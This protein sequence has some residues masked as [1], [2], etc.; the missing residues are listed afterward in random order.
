MPRKKR[1]IR[2]VDALVGQ[3]SDALLS[4][5]ISTLPGEEALSGYDGMRSHLADDLRSVTQHL[6]ISVPLEMTDGGET[7]WKFLEPN[8]L[9][10]HVIEACP[11]LAEAYGRA[12]NEHTPT[13][14]D[15]WNL[16]L[17]FDEFVPG[18][19]LKAYAS[20]K[21]MV[22]GFNFKELGEEILCKDHSWFIPV[23][24]RSSTIH[25]VL[26]GWS[27]MLAKFLRAQLLGAQGLRTSG[28]L[29]MINGSP[30]QIYANVSGILPDY[31]GVRIGWDWKGSNSMRPNLR[32]A[33][34]FKKGSDIAA[35]IGNSQEITC[36]DMAL[37]VERSNEDFLADVDLLIDAGAE[38][39]AGRLTHVRLKDFEKATGQTWNPLGFVSDLTLRQ[40]CQP[41]DVLNADWVHGVLS[42]GILSQEMCCFSCADGEASLRDYEA[43][44]KSDL[45]FPN[46]FR[47]KGAGLWRVFDEW[48]N[49]DDDELSKIRADA[50]ELLGLYALM[51]H[52][53]EKRFA[54][55]PAE[56]VAERA[57]FYACCKVVDIIL[58]MK[59]GVIDAR[60]VQGRDL[61][62][63]AMCSH[64]RLHIAAYGDEHVK[65]KHNLN[66]SLPNQFFKKGVFDAFT[67]ER[68]HLLVK[69]IAERTKNT[70]TFEATVL[71]RLV[72]TQIFA[73]TSLRSLKSGL[74]GK[75]RMQD[76]VRL[77]N[78]L[79]C[80]SLKV[81][82][83]DIVCCDQRSGVVRACA[84]ENDGQLFVIVA[85]LESQGSVTHHSHRFTP[86]AHLVVWGAETLYMPRAWY[87]V[88]GGDFVLIW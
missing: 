42:D 52:F 75:T 30:L 58:A 80:A 33:N 71:G 38:Y 87:V 82:A 7:E 69:V 68:L 29:V 41:L 76:G 86:T 53:I 64:L 16:L 26:G 17:S 24:V 12:A 2:G 21:S 55:R 48:R 73:L 72:R 34:V 44:M 28:A 20:R 81:A 18:D 4:R 59:T 54:D 61:L 45:R 84:S 37:L 25:D 11:E 31:D 47:A 36:A 50:S 22:L 27:H 8:R 49:G 60:S 63:D 79:E 57:S 39:A 40:H 19:K 88:D 1:C 35:R 46:H 65:P 6:L 51:R 3:C 83:G 62:S 32:F 43:F 85:H 66:L 9:L 14:D 78:K 13:P 74:R 5:I 77:S 67:S 56:L 70:S 15:P 10:A 23:V